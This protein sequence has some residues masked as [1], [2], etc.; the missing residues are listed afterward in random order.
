MSKKII[1]KRYVEIDENEMKKGDII[2]DSIGDKKEIVM[3]YLTS[4]LQLQE[5]DD[6]MDD[7]EGYIL[8]IYHIIY[9][10]LYNQN[11]EGMDDLIFSTISEYIN[12]NISEQNIFDHITSSSVIFT[13]K[14][15]IKAMDHIL[16]YMNNEITHHV[17]DMFEG[18][19]EF[20]CNPAFESLNSQFLFDYFE[21]H[22]DEIKEVYLKYQEQLGDEI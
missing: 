13:E 4:R 15:Y 1:V 16:T 11:I 5:Y 12:L 19:I 17:P 18:M 2:Q 21:K 6:I 14:D 10:L 7:V 9:D 20:E 8:S 22:F 3:K